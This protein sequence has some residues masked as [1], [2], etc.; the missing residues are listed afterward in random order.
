MVDS[1]FRLVKHHQWVVLNREHAQI[2]SDRWSGDNQVQTSQYW[3]LAQRA[4]GLRITARES[5]HVLV[6]PQSKPHN[7]NRIISTCSTRIGMLLK[8]PSQS[9]LSLA[10]LALVARVT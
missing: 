9:R 6:F 8:V 4:K 3:S 2:L 5:I 10:E 1:S 7:Q